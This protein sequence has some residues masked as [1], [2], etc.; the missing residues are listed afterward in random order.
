MLSAVPAGTKPSA[1]AYAVFIGCILFFAFAWHVSDVRLAELFAPAALGRLAANI[2]AMFPPKIDLEFLLLLA[3]PVLE[4]IAIAFAGISGAIALAFPLA[5]FAVR[6]EVLRS[7]EDAPTTRAGRAL[8]ATLHYG[9]RGLLAV[10]RTIPEM[11]WAL[12]FVHAIGLGMLPGVL[13]IALPYAGVIGKVF[14]EIIEGVNAG[15]L[16]AL[17]ALG[18]SRIK[19]YFFAALPQAFPLLLSYALYRFDCALRCSAVL[20]LVGAGGVGFQIELSIKMMEY[21]EVLTEILVL[22]GLVAASDFLSG[23]IRAHLA[24]TETLARGTRPA[25][26]GTWA[27]PVLYVVALA[28]AAVYCGA[29]PSRIYEAV[30]GFGDFLIRAFPPATSR[31]ELIQFARAGAE[32]IGI[33]FIGTVA[34]LLIAIPLAVVAA[35]RALVAADEYHASPARSIERA[36][37]ITASAFARFILNILRTIPMLI[38]ALIFVPA[39]GIGPF[40]GVLAVA[41]HTAGVFGRLYTEVIE[42]VNP[43]SLQTFRG[44]GAPKTGLLAVDHV[45]SRLRVW[46]LSYGGERELPPKSIAAEAELSA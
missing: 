40:A 44:F 2:G 42:E 24:A 32:T 46:L 29:T 18:A 7:L 38:F 6:P 33:S 43:S 22:F 26:R 30:T 39:I 37:W 21:G 31:D 34:A 1:K 3:R 19:I 27:A 20:G 35:R 13:A 14:S 15:P 10:L 8:E 4:T 9:A 16:I 5:F 11:V 41:F 17:R 23:R 25:R 12:M 36:A 28:A 45:S